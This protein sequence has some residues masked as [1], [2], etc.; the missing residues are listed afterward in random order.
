MIDARTQLL[1]LVGRDIAHSLSPSLHN[2]ALQR[3]GINAVYLAF[4]LAEE[5]LEGFIGI[6][7]RIGGIGLNVTTPHKAAAARLVAPGEDEVLRTGAV[8]T[9]AYRSGK[10]VGYET[11]GR[12]F[13]SWMESEKIP[14]GEGGLVLLGFGPANRSIAYQLG[15]EFPL[16]VVSRSAAEAESTLQSWYASGWPGLPSRAL[17]WG[18]RAPAMPSLVV[19]GLPPGFARS[20][21]VAGWLAELDP[22]SWLVDLNYGEGRTPLHDQA[23]DRGFNT[24]DGQGLL[25]HQATL[26]LSIWLGKSLDVSLLREGE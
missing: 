1:G 7:P 18:D 5:D 20:A 12:G 17:S 2:R 8:N 22:S 25:L 21:A 26:S 19:G 24:R 3:L 14:A 9:I 11:D 16:T 6:L 13:R 15:R 10:P 23:R 4:D